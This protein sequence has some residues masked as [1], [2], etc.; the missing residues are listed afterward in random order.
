MPT[1]RLSMR[2]IKQ[3]LTMRFGAGAST[4]EI[5]RSGHRAQH[6]A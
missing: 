5:A 3:L 1:Q 4:R 6:G 2:R